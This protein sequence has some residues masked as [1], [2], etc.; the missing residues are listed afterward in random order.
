MYRE[1]GRYE[2][3]RRGADSAGNRKVFDSR[4]ELRSV[5][6]RLPDRFTAT[7]VEHPSVSGS[8]RHLVVRHLAEHPAFDCELVCRRPLTVEKAES[9]ETNAER[10]AAEVPGRAD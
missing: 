2:I 7:D 4:A 5:Y 6:D 9:E 8:R 1:D 10:T 3:R